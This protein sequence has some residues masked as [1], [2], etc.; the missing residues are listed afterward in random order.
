MCPKDYLI[1]QLKLEKQKLLARLQQNKEAT[2][3]RL[4]KNNEKR[5]LSITKLTEPK[6]HEIVIKLSERLALFDMQYCPKCHVPIEKIGGCSQMNCTRC[7][8][9]FTW[10]EVG[11]CPVSTGIPFL[12]KNGENVVKLESVKEELYKVASLGE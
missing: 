7:G 5:L 6:Y 4:S 10:R 1:E 11:T 9:I 8:G 3:A 2:L 12:A